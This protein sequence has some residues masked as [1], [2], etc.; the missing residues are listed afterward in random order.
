[1]DDVLCV[2]HLAFQ[3]SSGSSGFDDWFGS[4]SSI[5]GEDLGVSTEMDHESSREDLDFFIAMD[6][7]TSKTSSAIRGPSVGVD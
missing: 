5:D 2:T 3:S 1:L 6:I 4:E 7:V